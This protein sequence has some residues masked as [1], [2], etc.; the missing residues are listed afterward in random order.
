MTDTPDPTIRHRPSEQV[1]EI[2]STLCDAIWNGK[3]PPGKHLWSIPVNMDRDFDMVLVDLLA[4]RDALFASDA[5]TRQLYANL[6]RCT[7]CDVLPGVKLSSGNADKCFRCDGTGFCTERQAAAPLTILKLENELSQTRLRLDALTETVAQLTKDLEWSKAETY[8][9]EEGAGEWKARAL[10]A[11]GQIEALRPAVL[12]VV[13]AEEELAGPMP[14]DMRGRFLADPAESMR[15]TVRATKAGIR[16]RLESVFGNDAGRLSIQAR[17]DAMTGERAADDER[18]R[19]AGARVG[20]W[21]G[22]DTPD[23]L[24]EEILGLRARLDALEAEKMALADEYL[25]REYARAEGRLMANGYYPH[26]GICSAAHWKPLGEPGCIC[27]RQFKRERNRAEK[28][29]A[30]LTLAESSRASLEAKLKALVGQWRAEATSLEVYVAS[31][32]PKRAL[33]RKCAAALEAALPLPPS[34]PSAQ[35]TP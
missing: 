8:A 34:S 3:V 11:E 10:S 29:E 4:E 12:A 22:C 20:I 9:I 25:E 23:W 18:L 30:Q 24:A 2:I 7:V 35:E 5:Q 32:F 14:L 27:D 21:Y 33:L 1:R 31:E 26:L 17:L 6:T 19:Q 28:A 16:A 15:A 13:D